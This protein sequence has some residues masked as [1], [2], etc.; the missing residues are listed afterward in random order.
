MNAPPTSLTTLLLDNQ[1]AY[2]ISLGITDALLT[3][4][5]EFQPALCHGQD[6]WVVQLDFSATFDRV[7]HGGYCK[8]WRTFEIGGLMPSIAMQFFR[9]RSH[10][11]YCLSQRFPRSAFWF[12]PRQR[13]DP[14]VVQYLHHKP[15]LYNTKSITWLRQWCDVDCEN[16]V[17]QEAL[18]SSWIH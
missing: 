11:V 6:A 3:I 8:S 17:P 9:G 13:S 1:F 18:W 10:R 15:V 12:S 14:I 5:H 4:P 2:R 16:R 7:H